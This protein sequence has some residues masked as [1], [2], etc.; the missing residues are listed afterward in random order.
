[1]EE[2]LVI[3]QCAVI[4]GAWDRHEIETFGRK[5]R[6]WVQAVSKALRW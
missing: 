4:A 2:I 5:K 1:L 3:A 6:D